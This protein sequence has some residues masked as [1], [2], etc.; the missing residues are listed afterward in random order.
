[1]YNEPTLC[2]SSQT[3]SRTIPLSRRPSRRHIPRLSRTSASWLY[4]RCRVLYSADSRY[5]YIA[6]LIRKTRKQTA[7]NRSKK[8][9]AQLPCSRRCALLCFP[10]CFILRCDRKKTIVE[11]G[12]TCAAYI[13]AAVY[14]VS[15]DH[16]E[17]IIH[18]IAPRL[19]RRKVVCLRRAFKSM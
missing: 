2:L 12:T 15:K 3:K 19:R 8:M 10:N 6:S 18:Q 4:N 9:A 14:K 11:Q 5:I 16:Y 17:Y 1:M 13:A 7:T